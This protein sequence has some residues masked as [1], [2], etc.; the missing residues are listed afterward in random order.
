MSQTLLLDVPHRQVVFTIPKRRRLFF[1][2]KRRLLG[3]RSARTT[4]SRRPEPAARARPARFP[5]LPAVLD[6]ARES[7]YAC[8]KVRKEISSRIR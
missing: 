2:Y 7:V 3:E 1:K 8:R 4:S 5:A 6:T